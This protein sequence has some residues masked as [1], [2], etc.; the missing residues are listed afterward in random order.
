MEDVLE[1]VMFELSINDWGRLSKGRLYE[2]EIMGEVMWGREGFPD[3]GNNI[4]QCMCG[5]I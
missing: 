5:Y 4:Y 3:R 2:V 1:E